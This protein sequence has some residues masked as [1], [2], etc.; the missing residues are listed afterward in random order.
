MKMNKLISA[1]VM[2]FLPVMIGI[3]SVFAAAP[4]GPVSGTIE[5]SGTETWTSD[6]RFTGNGRLVVTGDLT[7]ESST[8]VFVETV[9]GE[10][11]DETAYYY[12]AAD[13]NVTFAVCRNGEDSLHILVEGL[14]VTI[15][16]KTIEYGIREN[17]EHYQTEISGNMTDGFRIVNTWK[18]TRTPQPTDTPQ[19]T[20]LPVTPTSEPSAPDLFR[21]PEQLETLPQTG[22]PTK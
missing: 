14:P 15:D 18:P 8:I 13:P 2:I 17:Q 7:L 9:P 5:V 19:P 16:G 10:N 6:V 3:G 21:L 1:I 11:G 20:A 22:F 4:S 12:A